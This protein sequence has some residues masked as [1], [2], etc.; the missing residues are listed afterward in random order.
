MYAQIQQMKTCIIRSQPA[1]EMSFLCIYMCIL[2]HKAFNTY[3]AFVKSR[4][5]RNIVLIVLVPTP[6]TCDGVRLIKYILHGTT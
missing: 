2:V 4:L 5:P 1:L 3:C 6:V